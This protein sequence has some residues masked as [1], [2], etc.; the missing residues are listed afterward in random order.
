MQAYL[1]SLTQKT[2]QQKKNVNFEDIG[3]ISIS[4]ELDSSAHKGPALVKN[5]KF[6]KKNTDSS[7]TQ[8]QP[9]SKFLRK[10][11]VSSAS[12]VPTVSSQQRPG[13]SRGPTQPQASSQV[14]S[15]SLGQNVR[16]GSQQSSSLDK[17]AALSS[18]IS[19]RSNL[20]RKAMT[21]E[22]DS[23]DTFTTPR[24]P[25]PRNGRPGSASSDSVKI[26][27]DGGKF[28]KKKPAD[29][30]PERPVEFKPEHG[31]RKSPVPKP[32]K[33]KGQEATRKSNFTFTC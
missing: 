28:M 5:S 14:L 29:P 25:T 21:L 11:Q 30:S 9:Q 32:N 24:T 26:G 23:D 12:P 13:T 20:A 15:R 18:K 16:S 6:I 31:G 4:S 8:S 17:A 1:K 7:V 3:D 22:S 19:Q 10:P 33:L 27:K 2:A